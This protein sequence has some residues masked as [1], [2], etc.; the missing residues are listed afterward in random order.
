[1]LHFGLR[2]RLALFEF[3]RLFGSKSGLAKALTLI[4][5]LTQPTLVRISA[6]LALSKVLNAGFWP[7][8]LTLLS[9][10]KL[11]IDLL[12]LVIGF[13]TSLVALNITLN[14][15]L[16]FFSCFYGRFHSISPIGICLG[17]LSCLGWVIFTSDLIPLDI[18]LHVCHGTT[19]D[20]ECK[21]LWAQHS[22]RFSPLFC[23]LRGRL[24]RLIRFSIRRWT[25]FFLNRI[26]SAK[27][28]LHHR[29]HQ[30]WLVVH[31]NIFDV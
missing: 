1:M 14:S 7:L 26:G 24:P 15:T 18:P 11:H 2:N 3:G 10:E 21:Y 22:I 5:G 25:G 8:E 19:S 20:L 13:L 31:F 12:N 30:D 28:F 23:T 6:S 4:A 9:F 27:T 29:V 16:H 17:P